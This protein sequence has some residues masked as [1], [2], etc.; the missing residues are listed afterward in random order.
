MMMMM[1]ESNKILIIIRINKKIIINIDKKF[2]I[3]TFIT[4]VNLNKLIKKK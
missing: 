2:K 3:F 1:I 4:Y